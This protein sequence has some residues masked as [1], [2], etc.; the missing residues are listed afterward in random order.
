MTS[1]CPFSAVEKLMFV[2]IVVNYADSSLQFFTGDGIFYRSVRFG[3]PTGTI[4]SQDWQPFDPPSPDTIEDL[5]SDQL[6]ALIKK[7]TAVKDD[8]VQQA[9]AAVYLGALWDLIAKAI[10]TMPFPP[11]QYSAYAN[12]VVGKPLALVNVGWSLELA[13]PP[14][15][16]QHTLPAPPSIQDGIDPVRVTANEDMEKYQ[17]PVKIGDVSSSDI[18]TGTRADVLPSMNVRLMV[19]CRIGIQTMIQGASHIST[20]LIHISQQIPKIETLL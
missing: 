15:W 6:T 3:G 5:V 20:R 11:S 10:E 4:T 12:A 14:L 2:G 19:L 17:F 13:Q 18:Q 1:F 7:M 9:T 16:A 8:T